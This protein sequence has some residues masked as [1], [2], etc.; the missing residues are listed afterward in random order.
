MNKK[1]F[2]LLL[3]LGMVI[4]SVNLVAQKLWSLEECVAYAYENNIYIKQSYLGVE[5]AD[6]SLDQS[7]INLS[8]SFNASLSQNWRW[9]RSPSPQ[10]N[11]YSNEQSQQSYFGLS[12]DLTLFNGMQQVNNIR[13][14]QFDY[15]ASKYDSDKIKNDMSLN[16]AA[17]YLQI[18]F[19]IELVNNAQR[20]LD[21]SSQ[22]LDRTSKQVEAGA[23][24]KGSLY[25]IQAQAAS[26]E[27]NL[28]NAENNLMLAYLDLMQ[29]LDLEA[30]KE[31]DIVKPK[32]EITAKP[33]L[34]PPDMIYNK[35]VAIMP[36]IKSAEYKLQSA[37]R[38]LSIA[39][40]QRSP[41][42][43]ATGNYGTSFSDQI[44]NI[45]YSPEGIP[46]Y[47]DTKSFD[48]QIKDNRNGVL[49]FGLSIPIFNGYQVSS[50]IKQSKINMENLNLNLQLEKNRLRKNIEQSYADALAAYQTYIARKKS[51]DAFSES[52][53][54]MEEKFNVGMVNATDYNVSKL[55]YST[56]ISDL[57][58]S[59]FDYIFKTKILDF[60]LGKSISLDDIAVSEE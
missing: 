33:T 60:Y 51:V 24:A 46:S 39:K 15:L 25:D 50:Y 21:I 42:L 9:G 18:L 29:L 57:A 53:K 28:I 4:T 22:Q 58:A 45:E 8:P 38:G 54:Y 27:A 17:G 13:Q 41:R 36:E 32:L 6:L 5:S 1:A 12:T 43:Y 37:D 34:L 52:F 55:Q 59:K 30:N 44:K 10:T 3:L 19:N 20:Q 7:K 35:S 14:K 40:G 26:D 47:G 2:A 56:A 31:F 11:V 16:I 48:A 49:M 23:V